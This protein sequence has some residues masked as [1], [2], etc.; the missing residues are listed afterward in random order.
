VHAVDLDA[1][2]T[3]EAVPADLAAALLDDA[4]G[5]IGKRPEAPALTV[6]CTQSDREW[7]LGDGPG[8]AVAGSYAELLSW[9][10]GRGGAVA[11]VDWPALPAWL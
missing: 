7:R 10:L 2:V 4:L 8:G 5:S 6:R 9:A 3:F 11:A 1:G